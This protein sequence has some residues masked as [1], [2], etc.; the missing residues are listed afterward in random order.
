MTKTGNSTLSKHKYLYLARLDKEGRVHQER[1]TVVHI[2]KDYAFFRLPGSTELG[3]IRVDRVLDGLPPAVLCGILTE[4]GQGPFAHYWEPAPDSRL[5][6]LALTFRAVALRRRSQILRENLQDAE[7]DAANAQ[8]A[9]T[10]IKAKQDL[11]NERYLQEK[12][13][14]R[15]EFEARAAMLNEMI[16]EKPLESMFLHPGSSPC[17]HAEELIGH[18]RT[19]ATVLHAYLDPEQDHFLCC[20]V[21]FPDCHKTFTVPDYS[22]PDIL[23][24]YFQRKERHP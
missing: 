13:E 6:A 12:A 2:N 23:E 9:L 19:T 4:G 24:L 10:R 22:L 16:A 11:F 8:E 5:G 18:D 20:T 21:R 7:T 15:K 14:A 3:R 1:R 17:G